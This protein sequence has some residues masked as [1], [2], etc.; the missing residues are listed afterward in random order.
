[1]DYLY[2]YTCQFCLN[3]IVHS[4]N[5]G[6]L[7]VTR[8]SCCVRQAQYTQLGTYHRSTCR[9]ENVLEAASRVNNLNPHCVSLIPLTQRNHTRKWNPYMSRVRK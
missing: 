5:L 9:D 8:N 3:L 4:Q 1:M 6:L 7:L 2:I